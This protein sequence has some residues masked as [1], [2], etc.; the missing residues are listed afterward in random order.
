[1]PSSLKTYVLSIQRAIKQDWM[2]EIDL[3]KEL[4]FGNDKEMLFAIPNNRTE[5]SQSKGMDCKSHEVF[6]KSKIVK[7]YASTLLS[8]I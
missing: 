2:Y 3:Q 1:M 8:K 5:H 7:L 6:S 4:I